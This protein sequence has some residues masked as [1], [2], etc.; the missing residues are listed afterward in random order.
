[1]EVIA[2]VVGGV[3]AS[4]GSLIDVHQQIGGGPSVL[5]DAVAVI[6]SP[7]GC[8]ALLK[9]PA[10]KDFVSDAFTHLKFIGYVDAALPL[11]DKAG[12]AA[13]MDDGF[14]PLAK[15]KGPATFVA[16]CRKLRK[17]ERD[18]AMT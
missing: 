18:E 6:P 7:E 2:P 14:V 1:M 4:D 12:V 13:D 9:N 3:N 16:A 17:W 10:A 8:Q 15:T 11:L 5:Y